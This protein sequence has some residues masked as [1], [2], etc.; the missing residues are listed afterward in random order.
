[1]TSSWGP[2]EGEGGFMEKMVVK[3]VLEEHRNERHSN[4][5]YKGTEMI[6]TQISSLPRYGDN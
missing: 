1:M 3:W 5:T 2:W 4:K 6:Q